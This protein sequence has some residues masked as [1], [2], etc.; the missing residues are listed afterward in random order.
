MSNFGG[1]IGPHI[2]QRL[3]R[4]RANLSESMSEERIWSKYGTEL[5][6]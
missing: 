1:D 2:V 6:I 3:M 4:L 5:R